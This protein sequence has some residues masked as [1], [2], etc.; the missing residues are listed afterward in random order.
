LAVTVIQPMIAAG[1]LDGG[2]HWS[3]TAVGWCLVPLLLRVRFQTAVAVQAGFWL[4]D[5][6]ATAFLEPSAGSVGVLS[7]GAA[8]SLLPELA[9]LIANKLLGDAAAQ[10]REEGERQLRLR[11]SELIAEVIQDEYHRNYADVVEGVVSV[12][13]ELGRGQPQPVSP[14][15]RREAR[16]QSRCL[17][18]LLEQPES[19]GH[20]LMRALHA[21]TVAARDNGTDMEVQ[22]G[23]ELPDLSGDEIARLVAPVACLLREPLA[24]ARVA[25]LATSTEV[26][27]SVVCEAPAAAVAL[28]Q[29][30]LKG[31]HG[32]DVVIS[33]RSVWLTVSVEL[34]ETAPEYA[35]SQ[36][37]SA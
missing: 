2:T 14:E 24:S 32:V 33:D 37:Q 6:A 23:G 35:G 26:I 18:S 20:P 12:L 16:A 28:A 3:Q 1:R 11:T 22:L 15:M 17:R 4:L 25:V 21:P 27:A 7:L 34:D 36:K 31:K 13:T 10:A 29:R 5:A 19:R 30:A 8:T 9:A